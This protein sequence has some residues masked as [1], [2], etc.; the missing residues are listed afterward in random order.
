MNF[1]DGTLSQNSNT[2]VP[3]QNA[4]KTYVDGQI[5]GLN[6]DKILEGDTSVETIDSGSDGN[7]QFK[8]NAGLKLQIDSTG[9]T[10]LAL[11]LYRLRFINK[12]M[13]FIIPADMHYSM[14]ERTSVELGVVTQFR[15]VKTIYSF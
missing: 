4:V 1:T 8:I 7:I 3:T 11:I 6:A 14:K 13:E 12:E 5:A 15:K 2:K 10:I 9:H